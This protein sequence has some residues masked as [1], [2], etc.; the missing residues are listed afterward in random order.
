MMEYRCLESLGE[1]EAA[2]AC[3]DTLSYMLPRSLTVKHLLMRHCVERNQIGE[4]LRYADDILSTGFKVQSEKAV[5]ITN[6][7]KQLKKIYG[8]E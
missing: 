2:V 7:A 6:K 3:L 5:I 4:A 1:T 8:Y